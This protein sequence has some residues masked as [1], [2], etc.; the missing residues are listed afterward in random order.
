MRSGRRSL[1]A[2]AESEIT[3]ILAALAAA[4]VV[5]APAWIE[6]DRY[7]GRTARAIAAQRHADATQG[8]RLGRLLALVRRD[9]G[10][11]IYAGEPT[12]WGADL[13]VGAVPVFKYLEAR[14]IDEV[15]YTL[16]TASLMTDPEYYFDDTDISDYLVFGIRWLI[17]PVGD[18]PPVSASAFAK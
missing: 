7:D 6:L 17:V 8:A 1:R 11:R 18:R 16:R 5:L 9:G 4:I 12:N 15:G 14:D 2:L 10:G 3:P 13:T